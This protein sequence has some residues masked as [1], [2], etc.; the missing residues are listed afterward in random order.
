MKVQIFESS[1]PP[2]SKYIF[3]S[4]EFFSLVIFVLRALKMNIKFKKNFL[5]VSFWMIFCCN[6]P[7]GVIGVT[8]N[9]QDSA[10]AALLLSCMRR[11][12]ETVGDASSPKRQKI[13]PRAEVSRLALSSAGDP[14]DK[15]AHA[16][17]SQAP[18]GHNSVNWSKERV[19]KNHEKRLSLDERRQ[20]AQCLDSSD[21]MKVK[22]GKMVPN[23]AKISQEIDVDY[24]T[25]WRELKK[26]CVSGEKYDPNVAHERAEHRKAHPNNAPFSAEALQTIIERWHNPSEGSHKKVSLNNIASTIGRCESDTQRVFYD[27]LRVSFR[28]DFKNKSIYEISDMMKNKDKIKHKFEEFREIQN[29]G[30]YLKIEIEKIYALQKSLT[31]MTSEEKD[32]IIKWR[33]EGVCTGAISF[34]TNIS[35]HQ[36]ESIKFKK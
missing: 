23:L 16:K 20:I 18:F 30:E 31:H 10:D 26:N 14:L 17:R 9:D 22:N 12:P 11:S 34:K 33:K 19:S 24:S 32:M 29:V 28:E 1:L 21:Y 27:I 25:I 6:S 15:T 2:P 7:E 4:L 13:A 36:I 3:F 35:K 5:N 8:E